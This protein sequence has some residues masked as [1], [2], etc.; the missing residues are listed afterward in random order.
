MLPFKYS[1]DSRSFNGDTDFLSEWNDR[2]PLPDTDFEFLEPVLA[3]RTSILQTLVKVRRGQSMDGLAPI[4]KGI[5]EHLEVQAKVAREA[6][7][8]QVRKPRNND[9]MW[10][11]NVTNH[12]SY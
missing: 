10:N 5:V 12:P 11:P 1:F 2:F 3:L 4:Y 7:N 8:P 9:H 6:K